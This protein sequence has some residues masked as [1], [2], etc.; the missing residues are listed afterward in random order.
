MISLKRIIALSLCTSMLINSSTSVVSA[1]IGNIRSF[2]IASNTNN[3]DK[4]EQ[5]KNSIIWISKDSIEV[6]TEFNTMNGVKAYDEDGSD[7][8]NSIS[9]LGQVDN[10]KPGEYELEYCIK[11]KSGETI[12]RTRK[13]TVKESENKAELSQET[14][15]KDNEVLNNQENVQEVK[16]V[17]PTFTRTYLGEAFNDKANI[18]AIDSNGKDIISLITVEGQ[19][20]VNKVGSYELKYSVADETGKTA[21]LTRKVN[22]I[23]KNIFNKYIEK[24]N[25]E[26]KE[27]IKE[28]GFSIYLDNNTSKFLVENQSKEQLDP[29]KKDE[30]VFKIRVIDK[31]NKEKLKIELLGSDTGESEKLNSLKELEYSF[32]DYIEINTEEAKERFTIEGEMSGDIKAKLEE[33]AT[34]TEQ[35]KIEDYSDGVDNI[36][37]LLNVRF[38]I[39]EEGIETVYNKAPEV[40]GLQ[41]MEKLL[42]ER[43]SQLEGISVIDDH[44]GNI[45]N[46]NIEIYEEKNDEGKTIGLRYEV[47]DSW[48]RRVSVLR[49]LKSQIESSEEAQDIKYIDSEGNINLASENSRTGTNSSTTAGNLSK[50]VITVKGFA[51]SDGNDGRF[52]IKFNG[53]TNKIEIYD[54]DSRL[55]D[56]KITDKYF[57]IKL[58]SKTGTLKRE[59]TI[60]GSDRAD[61]KKI[62]EFNNTNFEFGDQIEIYHA[63]S[64][65]KLL[66]AGNI[67]NF[68]GTSN[69][70]IPKNK[71]ESARFELTNTGMKYLTNRPPTIT[72]PDKEL[73]VTAGKD[74]DLLADITVT[75]DIDKNI[76]K[77]TV[78]VTAY[79]PNKLGEQTVTYSVKDSWGAIGTAE[80]TIRVVSDGALANT[81]IKIKSADGSKDI[82][83][84]G[85]DDL[86]KKL[87]IKNQTNDKLNELKPNELALSLKIISKAGITKKEIKLNGSASGQSNQ[88][89]ALNGYRYNEGDYIE[90]WSPDYSKSIII[91]GSIE[92]DKEITEDYKDGVK[93]EDF[94]KNVRFRLDKNVLFA[95]YN[96]APEIKFK[97]DLTIKRGQNFNPLDFIE[98]IEDDYDNL[99][100]NLVKVSYNKA[101]FESVGEYEVAYKISDSWG[102]VT[103][104]KIKIQVIEKN[105]LE[106]S[107]IYFLPNDE[108]STKDN[109]IVTFA[110]DDVNKRLHADIKE[111]QFISG[112]LNG[113]ALEISIFNSTG[114]LKAKSTIGYNSQI[115]KEALSEVLKATIEYD[116]MINVYAY[117]NKKI[118]ITGLSS[119]G[120]EYEAGFENEDK[121]VNTR[122]KV[123]KNGL[124]AIYNEAPKFVGIDDKIIMKNES[125]E[126]LKD[127]SVTDDHDN[128][129]PNEKIEIIGTI[130]TSR[131]GYQTLTYK[132]TD[133][134]GRSTEVTRKVFVRPL[135]E[136]NKIILKNSS[137]QDAFKIGFDFSKMRFTVEIIDSN[138][139]LNSENTGKEFSLTVYNSS[140]QRVETFELKG[141]D[142]LNEAAFDKLKKIPLS[143][144]SQ[145]S[146]WANTSSNLRIE[147]TLI[148]PSE[149]TENYSDGID[150]VEYMDNVRFV[151]TEDGM[152]VV[153]NKAPVITLPQ[154]TNPNP[155]V[156]YKGDDYR[157]ELLKGVTVSDPNEFDNGI[158]KNSIEIKLK[159][160]KNNTENS[161]PNTTPDNTPNETPDSTTNTTTESSSNNRIS[162]NEIDS[163]NGTNESTDLENSGQDSESEGS[164]GDNSSENNSENDNPGGSSG[165]TGGN[166]NTD[167]LGG[168]E[169]S[170]QQPPEN[171]SGNS[172]ENITEQFITLENL[173]ELGQYDVYYTIADSW[174]R[175]T[176]VIRRILLQSSIVRNGIIFQGNPPTTQY[177]VGD[178]FTLKFNI[179]TKKF[180]ITEKNTN[181]IFRYNNNNNVYYKMCIYDKNGNLKPNGL[182]ELRGTETAD[183]PSA[184]KL[185]QISFDYGDYIKFDPEHAIKIK[186]TGTVR[187]ELEDYS[188]GGNYEDDFKKTRFYITEE[189]LRSV[190][191]PK[192][193]NENQSIIEFTG[194]LGGKPFKMVFDHE[195]KQISYPSNTTQYYNYDIKEQTALKVYVKKVSEQNERVAVNI[196][197]R[198]IGVP[199]A[200]KNIF[201]NSLFEDGDYIRFEYT[202]IPNG[203]GISVSGKLKSDYKYENKIISNEDI[204]NIRFYLRSNNDSKYLEPVYN[205]PPEFKTTIGSEQIDGLKDI[206]IYEDDVNTFNPMA[207]VIVV[208]DNDKDKPTDE[209]TVTPPNPTVTN[210]IGKY[211]YTYTATDSWGKRTTATRNVYV[212]PSLFKNKIVLYPKVNTSD[213]EDN[214][215]DGSGNG[216]EEDNR[217]NNSSDNIQ[218]PGSNENDGNLENEENSRVGS[219]LEQGDG[220]GTE[221]HPSGGN[222]SGVEAP[223]TE[224]DNPTTE[225]PPSEGNGSES[226][227]PPSSGDSNGDNQE[228]EDTPSEDDSNNNQPST[229]TKEKPAF[230]IV[231]DNDT[232]K[233]VVKNRSNKPINAKLGD[234]PAF[235]IRIYDGAGHVRATIE[236]NGSDTGESTKLDEL[237]E[238]N[239]NYGDTIRV[240]SADT[241]SLR[242]TGEVTKNIKEENQSKKA[243]FESVNYEEGTDDQDYF[244]NVA[245]KTAEAGLTAYYNKAPEINIQNLVNKNELNILFG[246][247]VNLLNG[248]TVSDDRDN[249]S[250]NIIEIIG[251]DLVDK[252]QIGSYKVTYKLTD[253]WG[254]SSSKEVTVNVISNMTNNEI[255]AYGENSQGQSEHKFTLKFNIY[256]NKLEIVRKNHIQENNNNQQPDTSENSKEG[257]NDGDSSTTEPPTTPTEPSEPVEPGNQEIP[258]EP[259]ESNPPE[260]GENSGDQEDTVEPPSNPEGGGD[261]DGATKP[262]KEKYFQIIVTN[263]NGNEKA[264]VILSKDE[265]NSDE[266]LKKLTEINIFNDDIISLYSVNANHV[267]IKGKIENKGTDNFEEGFTN[268]EQFSNVKFKITNKG[269]E[270][271]K[272]RELVMEISQNLSVTRGNSEELL[273]GINLKY[274]DNNQIEN[275]SNVN[276]KVNNVDPLKT[277]EY[278]AE[279]ILTDVWGRTIK[280][281]RKVTVVERNPLEHNRIVLKD[282]SNNKELMEFYIDTIN[283]RIITRKFD[284]EYTGT[285]ET[286]IKLTL[287]DENGRTKKSIEVT[288]DNLNSIEN[289][290]I[291]YDYTDLIG[292]SD[293]YNVKNG[294]IIKGDIQGK[295]EDYSNGV[296]NNDYIDNVRFKLIDEKHGVK[297]IYNN[298]PT[299]TINGEL[300]LFKDESPDLYEGV[301]ANDTDEHDKGVS[302]SDIVIDTELDITRIGTYTATYILQDTWGRETTKI[303]QIV[304]K[305]SLLNNKIQF[306]KK[307]NTSND[308]SD[309]SNTP[310]GPSDSNGADSS[311]GSGNDGEENNESVEVNTKEAINQEDESTDDNTEVDTEDTED[312]ETDKGDEKEDDKEDVKVNSLF[313][314]SLDLQEKKFIVT[315]NNEELRKVRKETSKL[316]TKTSNN[317]ESVTP[318]SSEENG[319]QGSG[320]ISGGDNTTTVPGGNESS[321]GDVTTPGVENTNQP[322]GDNTQEPGNGDNTDSS[323]DG[324]GTTVTTKPGV[325]TVNPNKPIDGVEFEFKLFD[326]NGNV[327]KELSITTKDMIS[328]SSIN[329]KLDNFNETEFVFGDYISIYAKQDTNNVRITGNIDKPNNIKEDYSTGISD[330]NYMY[331]VRFKINED[332]MDAI[333]NEAPTIKILEPQ[334]EI[335][336]YCGDDI[337]YGDGAEI[338]D[339]HDLDIGSDNITLSEDDKKEMGK[340]GKHKVTLILTDSWGRSVSVQRT[341]N[342]KTSIDRNII[343][344]I[345]Y[346]KSDGDYDVFKLKFD[347]TTKQIKVFNRANKQIHVHDDRLFFRITV[348]NGE[349]NTI[350]ESIELQARDHGTDNKLNVL[351]NLEFKYGDYI[352][353]YAYQAKRV[354]ISGPVRNQLED[355]SDGVDL[356]DDLS[357]TYFYITEAGLKS[358][359]KPETLQEHESLIEFIATNGGTPFKIKFNHS[360]KTVSFPTTTEFYNY[361]EG[362][363]KNVFRVKYYDASANNGSGQLFTYNSKNNDSTVNQ[364]LRGKLQNGFHDNDYLAFEYLDIPDSFYG[365]RLTGKVEIG[366][367]ADEDLKN[368]DYSDG[369]QNKRNL[370]EVRFYLNKGGQQ[371][372]FPVRVPA[373][374]ITGADDIDVLQNTRFNLKDHV[375]ATDS[376]GTILTGNMTVTGDNNLAR[377]IDSNWNLDTSRIGLY[378][379]KYEVQNREGIKTT[380]YRN[381][382]VYTNATLALRD[383]SQKIV[384]E[385]GAYPTDES[386]KA[387]L[388]QFVLAQ[389]PEA[390]GDD[391]AEINQKLTDKIDVDVSKINIEKPGEYD[392]TYSV[393]NDY[394]K[395]VTLPAKVSVV[396]TINVSV[397]TTLPF[398]VVTNLLNTDDTTNT[399]D[400]FVSGVLKL[401]NN[402]TSDVRVSIESFN[403]EDNSGNLDIVDPKTVENWDDLSKEESMSK[404]SL[405]IFVKSGFK[406]EA[407][408]PGTGG[409]S[410]PG[411]G[412]ES[413]PDNSTPGTSE[414]S[415]P[416]P[417]GSTS[418]GDSSEDGASGGTGGGETEG[419]LGSSEDTNQDSTSRTAN[420]VLNGRKVTWLVPNATEETFMGILPR[421]ESLET[422]SEGKL[423]FT[424]KHGKN[425]IGGTYKGKFKLVFKFE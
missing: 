316:L 291:D 91:S 136:N 401:K 129:I 257:I 248:V 18:Q 282:S 325:G 356:A 20:D 88:I 97:S 128:T 160:V 309:V 216:A 79:N 162:S 139:V 149:V 99:N 100:K 211:V 240:W 402:K 352:N 222:N 70:G 224:S 130:D 22:V 294:L 112:S 179:N 296:D 393:I 373:A 326:E 319:P 233:Y 328:K 90:L 175:E 6:G 399:Q 332:A 189:G 180:E 1:A 396:R 134:W 392:I 38:K 154:D 111:S 25:E 35:D 138:T 337:D 292:I 8:T 115:D 278:N 105:D 286:L 322:N 298:A 249:L 351:D 275:L 303:R 29:S 117:S 73:V 199:Q 123:T 353:I 60:N 414:P 235:K 55:F 344:F 116:D 69:N 293:L 197:G 317:E 142:V 318:D 177:I 124:E 153:Y 76:K 187:D 195:T 198:T 367:D 237:N 140:G 300:T 113:N 405:G 382:R 418:G 354:K 133:S 218:N 223:P 383:T 75:D 166:D 349:N 62:D 350:K 48:G 143:V 236:L 262:Q 245:F 53:D 277:G 65:S 256:T 80:R 34:A 147:G 214:N 228:T 267:K 200:L 363:Q 209:Y 119:K 37:Y 104:E 145:I 213:N 416:N 183:S 184:Q 94:I 276:I 171:N 42:T 167:N 67:Q 93:T 137:S 165:S 4:S 32:G 250:P 207:D 110:F 358:E 283:K 389:D 261:S 225:N 285:E 66:I 362:N 409:D 87:L 19:V 252:N 9:V 397:P 155:F 182:I 260:G 125:F 229:E 85:F 176:Q 89:T 263:R 28:L 420:D 359:F 378:Y 320:N 413:N 355:Y 132:V 333:Y 86:E 361:I 264:N 174:G 16:I 212:R 424:S 45:S 243:S 3:N 403:K 423:S 168:S 308:N 377:N 163:S 74:V 206:D 92:K 217:D 265:M 158:N 114:E 56:N 331:N 366:E 205:N 172:T 58:Y 345:G 417:D 342:V 368:E 313:E 287:Y 415:V 311:N 297:S 156:L 190:L 241:K 23:N 310:S 266:P 59:L 191:E 321:D 301:K 96:K 251:K 380:V 103:E 49:Y 108:A 284:N 425:F 289:E 30:V 334:K 188:D 43:S 406:D 390:I 54:R 386:K 95:K 63:Y 370:T 71:L 12:K 404:M 192:G 98:K 106:K 341:Y 374:T 410:N 61:N 336:V 193:L 381:I 46:D 141:T 10:S 365:L 315:K 314:I 64:D 221:N 44:D 306:Y 185:N 269:F 126:P 274:R 295:K 178:A 5:N 169:G 254:R 335:D 346:N 398:Q 360:D 419:D 226:Q 36:D 83:S 72:W 15:N 201:S 164:S 109:A 385:Q 121:M 304:V 146:L 84:I 312:T 394:Q 11:N 68:D 51:Y 329:S 2:S 244:N 388:K 24:I 407:S 372:I 340:I 161:T 202:N 81:D 122:F 375:K 299:I 232:H 33:G 247:E 231:F 279:Y 227:E 17:G 270:L 39:T 259:G 203:G 338:S 376:D 50:N 421:A 348:Y 102:R 246:E 27:K 57:Q 255:E 14:T 152:K 387:F 7:I 302:E 234:N 364:E 411:S 238:V 118:R 204:Q 13:V 395:K 258:N 157:T 323:P 208:D 230:E 400:P 40:R 52:K 412:S 148:K 239:F 347:S 330:P 371:G 290:Y 343:N 47:S 77:S 324:D 253:T 422:P 339:D 26:T 220:L 120:S 194:T 268:V 288:K 271:I 369:I 391:A 210:G 131:A 170:E 159:K 107:R 181:L 144:G 186:I 196:Q 305:S 307:D 408:N 82:F 272:Y 41:P 379:A 280:Q 31:D 281:T 219:N 150:D 384:M 173:T 101:A 215:Q 78:S 21:T 327:K 127:I 135:A 242:I 273:N 357:S 151:G